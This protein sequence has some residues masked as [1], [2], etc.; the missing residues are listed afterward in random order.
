MLM[1]G[2]RERLLVLVCQRQY[3]PPM[4]GMLCMRVYTPSDWAMRH[5]TTP[6]VHAHNFA[7][8]PR[9][10]R[11]SRWHASPRSVLRFNNEAQMHNPARFKTGFPKQ[12]SPAPLLVR[13][14]TLEFVLLH[15]YVGNS[16]RANGL[17][18]H[19]NLQYTI[20]DPVTGPGQRLHHAAL[21]GT[22]STPGPSHYTAPTA[23]CRRPPK[24]PY[25]QI[26]ARAQRSPILA[27][28]RLYEHY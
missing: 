1:R 18:T 12:M 22:S 25:S 6:L 27:A 26:K 7:E 16:R 23:Q 20:Q 10:S 14:Q 13:P 2:L 21:H 8:A 24:W 19:Q 4:Y 3:W 15:A 9:T 28:A 5:A 11:L 17:R